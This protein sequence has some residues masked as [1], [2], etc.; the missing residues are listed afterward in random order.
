[1]AGPS[2]T[3]PNPLTPDRAGSFDP[4]ATGRSAVANGSHD[5]L[6]AMLR[7][8]GADQDSAPSSALHR[9]AQILAPDELAI[10]NERREA[11]LNRLREDPYT[12]DFF[13]CMRRMEA[14]HPELPGVGL[15][16]RAIED[17]IRFCQE[18]SLAF[19]PSNLRKYTPLGQKSPPRLYVSFM[20]L[21]GPN[22]PLPLHLTDHARQRE[23]HA[24]DFTFSRFLDVFNHRM[25]SLFYRAWAACHMPASADRSR[26]ITRADLSQH[27]RDEA[28]RTDSNRYCVYVG[29]LL[30]IGMDSLRHRDSI[31]DIAKL[32]LSG[33]LVSHQRNAEGLVSIISSYFDLP[34]Q[35]QEFTGAWMDLPQDSYCTLG[36]STIASA[37]QI[38]VLSG[39]SAIAGTRVWGAHA[40]FKLRLGP[41]SIHTFLSLLPG[42]ANERRLTDWVKLYCGDEFSWEATVVLRKSDV[43]QT[44]LGE[45]AMLGYTTWLRSKP[46]TEDRDD[47]VLRG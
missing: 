4:D 36:G 45:K 6:D 43:P 3:T 44:R 24:K 2:R 41:V 9:Q 17:P 39:G 47:M 13:Q 12:L 26:F 37:N 23:I 7:D 22:G 42:S 25:V 46:E 10:L 18:P 16:D 32:H 19:A 5:P 21:L 35:I 40:A 1:M 14:L 27:D 20:G 38:G 30:G 8:S 33:R 15:S 34:V 28:L 31:A 11:F 29:S